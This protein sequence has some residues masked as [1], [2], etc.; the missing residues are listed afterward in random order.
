[1]IWG[2]SETA[3]VFGQQVNLRFQNPSILQ[4]EYWPI[5]LKRQEQ[6]VVSIVTQ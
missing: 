3:V 1:M 4:G 2:S 6:H 5:T